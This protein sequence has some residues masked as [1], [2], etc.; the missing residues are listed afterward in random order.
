MVKNWTAKY[1]VTNSLEINIYKLKRIVGNRLTYNLLSK[2]NF[3]S[4][5][6]VKVA[7]WCLTLCNPMDYTVHGI[8]QARLLEWVAFPFSR[9][10]SQPR[11]GTGVSCMAG[12][13]SYFTYGL[14]GWLS[15][16]ESAYQTEDT[17]SVPVS[18]RFAGEGNGNPLQCNCLANPRDR[19][20]GAL[21]PIWWQRLSIWTAAAGPMPAGPMQGPA[22]Q[23]HKHLSVPPQQPCSS[24]MAKE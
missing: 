24:S 5:V 3:E 8:P 15:G 22:A 18:G 6:K 19:E 1:E 17:D 11:D 9:G 2:V 13:H 16:K 4:Q 23:R 10:S 14:P 21:Q 20:S 7:Q 12:A